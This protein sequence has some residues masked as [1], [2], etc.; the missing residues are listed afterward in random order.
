[1]WLD[2]LPLLTTGDV[3]LVETL[4][5][6]V[7]GQSLALPARQTFLF[8]G[9]W[10]CMTT[11]RLSLAILKRQT[12]FFGVYYG[13]GAFWASMLKFVI[14]DFRIRFCADNSSVTSVVEYFWTSGAGTLYNYGCQSRFDSKFRWWWIP[15]LAL[16]ERHGE[17]H[18]W[19]LALSWH[20]D[21]TDHWAEFLIFHWRLAS[22]HA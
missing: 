10:C 12:F 17:V 22:L 15:L 2:M 19:N 8:A 5:L 18:Y 16:A 9:N 11:E 13:A 1:M 21:S 6:K 4:F 3:I 20:F 14:F 7:H